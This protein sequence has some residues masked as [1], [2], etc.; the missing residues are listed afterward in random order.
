LSVPPRVLVDLTGLERVP[1]YSHPVRR[2]QLRDASRSQHGEPAPQWP[3]A[4]DAANIDRAALPTLGRLV[5]EGRIE[6]CTYHEFH[7]AAKPHGGH[8]TWRDLLGDVQVTTIEPAISRARLGEDVFANCDQPGSLVR[9]CARLKHEDWMP[10]TN[11]AL[12]PADDDIHGVERFRRMAAR[13]QGDHLANLF[14]LWSAERAGCTYW[15]AAD[16]TFEELLRERVEP[17]LTP[18]LTCHVVRPERLLQRLGVTERDAASSDR[19]CVVSMMRRPSEGA[20]AATPPE[21]SDV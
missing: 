8:N 14:H 10:A 20:P 3:L 16:E 12:G 4:A 21:S 18:P 6:L 13:V 7:R 9:L 11:G 1:I 19:G 5:R 15:L 2:V 17:D